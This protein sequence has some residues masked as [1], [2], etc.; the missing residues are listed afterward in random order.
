M[1]TGKSALNFFPILFQRFVLCSSTANALAFKT[2]F[3]QEKTYIS[4]SAFCVT[5]NTIVK[6]L[7]FCRHTFACKKHDRRAT[8]YSFPY[9][10]CRVGL[11]TL[12]SSSYCD[13]DQV[14]RVVVFSSSSLRASTVCICA[15]A[16]QPR[17]YG[18]TPRWC[19][20]SRQF[21]DN[22]ATARC[23]DLILM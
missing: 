21:K 2:S 6:Y 7:H 5:T 15:L 23:F 11:C 8:Q 20:F 16:L 12:L 14:W 22:G 13:N 9:I 1:D 19:T 17:D 3:Y 4:Q 10:P 18:A